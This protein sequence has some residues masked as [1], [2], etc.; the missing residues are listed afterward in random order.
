MALASVLRESGEFRR[1]EAELNRRVHEIISYLDLDD[2]AHVA[3]SGLPFGTQKRVELARALAADPKIRAFH[4]RQRP[5]AGFAF[6]EMS[7]EK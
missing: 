3:V 2:V 7:D 1:D 4:G 5:V 6:S